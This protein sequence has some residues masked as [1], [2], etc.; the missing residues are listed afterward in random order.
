M[1]NQTQAIPTSEAPASWNTRYLSPTGFVCQLT[2]R[3]DTGS[4]L[5][6]KAT[7]ALTKLQASGCQ[8]HYNSYK[9]KSN[10]NGSA[11]K[12]GPGWCAF[13]QVEMRRREK[14]GKVWYSHKDGEMWCKG[15]SKS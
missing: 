1:T 13:H 3:G 10:G 9:A 4:E 6:E 8:P 12:T 14:D 5:L 7:A 15:K 2:I 11:D